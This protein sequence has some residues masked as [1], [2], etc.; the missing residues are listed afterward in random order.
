MTP[1]KVATW[2][3]SVATSP[4]SWKVRSPCRV[5]ATNA[6]FSPVTTVIRSFSGDSQLTR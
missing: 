6:P 5:S 3:H 2:S 4:F 1:R